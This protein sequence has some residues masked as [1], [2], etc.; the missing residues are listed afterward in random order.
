MPRAFRCNHNLSLKSDNER[1]GN[2][3]KRIAWCSINNSEKIGFWFHWKTQDEK[4]VPMVATPVNSQ[5]Y[6]NQ[7]GARQDGRDEIRSRG[8]ETKG[9]QHP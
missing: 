8:L 2:C 7:N 1:C 3:G 4:C 6:H 9:L 5:C